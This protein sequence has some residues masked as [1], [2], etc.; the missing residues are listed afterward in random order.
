MLAN[1]AHFAV[2]QPA[3]TLL[4]DYFRWQ[5]L[6]NRVTYSPWFLACYARAEVY[7]T[8]LWLMHY[9]MGS[10]KRLQIRSTWKHIEKFNLGR[11]T[12]M[13]REQQTTVKTTRTEL[14]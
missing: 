5:W 6:E 4:F 8:S 3:Q 7:K 14:M 11:L 1:H 13:Q 12:K 2:E 10:P 9:G